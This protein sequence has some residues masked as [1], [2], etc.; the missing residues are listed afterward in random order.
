MYPYVQK[1]KRQ[2]YFPCTVIT[3]ISFSLSL[4]ACFCWVSV[5]MSVSLFVS[6]CQL[7]CC[8]N[9]FFFYFRQMANSLMLND[10]LFV[11]YCLTPGCFARVQTKVSW[12]SSKTV[13]NGNGERQ[14]MGCNPNSNQRVVGMLLSWMDYWM[15]I[16][17]TGP[18][19]L[20]QS[21]CMIWRFLLESRSND[22]KETKWSKEVTKQERSE[23]KQLHRMQNKNTEMQN[24]HRKTQKQPQRCKTTTKKWEN[25]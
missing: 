21:P 22:Y 23:I 11:L 7:L 10:L 12:H 18:G 2:K 24:D 1:K 3:P 9:G 6:V 15:G 16:M 4:S 14:N 20:D 19:P 13:W 5:S 17:D 8:Q 25:P